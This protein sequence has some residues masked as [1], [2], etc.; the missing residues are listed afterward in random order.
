MITQKTYLVE[1]WVSVLL[2]ITVALLSF[3]AS[4]THAQTGTQTNF[5]PPVGYQ[6]VVGYPGVFFS[7]VTGMYF[8]ST[9]GYY[10]PNN[11]T[12]PSGYL[13]YG[14]YGVYYNSST[15]TYY[16]PITGQYSNIMPLG[17]ASINQ[18]GAYVVPNGYNL[19]AYGSYYS[20]T[21]GLYY[22]PRTGFY[23]SSAPVGPTLVTT[24]GTTGGSTSGTTYNPGLPNTGAGGDS[25][26]NLAFLA[27]TGIVGIAGLAYL[28]RRL[29]RA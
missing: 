6:S 8:Y 11:P 14:N 28:S 23:S 2:A 29:F 21:T 20:T 16:N 13:P 7:P 12:I 4:S 3:G 5:N 24:G 10:T 9:S 18:G 22:D 26:S 19:A 25:S 1:I 17:P 27:V 15:N